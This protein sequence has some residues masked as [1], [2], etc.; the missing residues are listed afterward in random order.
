MSRRD[1]RQI[2]EKMRSMISKKNQNRGKSKMS[3]KLEFGHID[4][5]SYSHHTTQVKDI[6]WNA[7]LN[8]FVSY[9][10]K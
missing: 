8:W 10:E 2:A 3:K 6:F 1:S 7:N 4:A 9:D 5:W